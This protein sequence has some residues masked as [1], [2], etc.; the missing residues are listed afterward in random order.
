G[1]IDPWIAAR[2]VPHLG[3]LRRQG[4]WGPLASTVPP[5]TF[6]SWSTFMTGVNPGKHGIFDFTRRQ[7]GSYGVQF[8]NASFRKAPTIWKLLSDAGR[9]VGVLGVPGT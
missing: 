9:R 7:L 6:P 8:V 1:L 2:R 3:R 5:T 4:L